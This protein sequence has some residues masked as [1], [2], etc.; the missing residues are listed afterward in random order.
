MWFKEGLQ[1]RIK[2]ELA[3]KCDTLNHAIELASRCETCLGGHKTVSVNYASK[4]QHIPFRR[5]FNNTR[6]KPVQSNSK[7]DMSNIECHRCHLKGHIRALTCR[8]RL[9]KQQRSNQGARRDDKR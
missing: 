7:R 8:V 2:L 4:L 6:S 1:L 5:P 3:K 9:D